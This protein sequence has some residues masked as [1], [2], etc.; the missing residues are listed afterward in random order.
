M[1]LMMHTEI[2]EV[3]NNYNYSLSNVVCGLTIVQNAQALF[4]PKNGSDILR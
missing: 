4:L 3:I 2:I 1:L